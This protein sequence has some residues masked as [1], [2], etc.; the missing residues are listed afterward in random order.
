[1][2]IKPERMAIDVFRRDTENQWV[3]YSFTAGDELAFNS[4]DF[5]CA[6]AALYEDVSLESVE[7]IITEN[8]RTY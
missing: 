2:L 5:H 1:V 7:H 6:I 8:N 4:I 3:L